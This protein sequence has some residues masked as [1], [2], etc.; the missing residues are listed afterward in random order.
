MPR[1][2]YLRL[3]VSVNPLGS[4]REVAVTR[5]YGGCLTPSTHGEHVLLYVIREGASQRHLAGLIINR[6]SGLPSRKLKMM[7]D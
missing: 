1:R 3:S 2:D 7:L 4:T 6:D 5:H